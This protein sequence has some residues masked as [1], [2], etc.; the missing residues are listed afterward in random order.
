MTAEQK[1]RAAY[2]NAHHVVEPGTVPTVAVYAGDYICAEACTVQRAYRKACAYVEAGI[3]QP[4]PTEPCTML[5][6]A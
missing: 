4:D 1:F 5:V 3:I 6:S 2:P